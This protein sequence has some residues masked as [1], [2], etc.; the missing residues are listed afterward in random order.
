MA[1]AQMGAVGIC[2]PDKFTRRGTQMNNRGAFYD[3]VFSFVDLETVG[4]SLSLDCPLPP[5]G[6]R[7]LLSVTRLPLE[8]RRAVS[9]L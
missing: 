1:L 2:R 7:L 9:S 4:R 8:G 3:S 6:L 5:L